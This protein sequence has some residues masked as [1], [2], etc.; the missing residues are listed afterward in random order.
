MRKRIQPG[1]TVAV[2][3]TSQGLKDKDRA[4]LDDVARRSAG[5]ALTSLT[6]LLG[7]A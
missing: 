3:A 1:R 5:S 7:F 4:W 2:A 6:V